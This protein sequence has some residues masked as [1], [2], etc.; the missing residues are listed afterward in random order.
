MAKLNQDL[1]FK[2]DE[3]TKRI[4]HADK[5]IEKHINTIASLSAQKSTVDLS[6]SKNKNHA[7]QVDLNSK[8]V[9]LQKFNK[10]SGLLSNV[11]M[12]S[13]AQLQASNPPLEEDYE[14]DQ[15]KE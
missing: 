2:I 5:E 6:L 7:S 10:Q 12:D 15:I 1:A 14:E 4:D 11:N 13:Q 3:M 9:G 8:P